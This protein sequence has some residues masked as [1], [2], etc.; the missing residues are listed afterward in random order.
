MG[1]KY[2]SKELL[3]RKMDGAL[4][5]IWQELDIERRETII[6]EKKQRGEKLFKWE[7]VV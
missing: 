7:I 1:K 2:V 5:R 3:L 6:N 4:A